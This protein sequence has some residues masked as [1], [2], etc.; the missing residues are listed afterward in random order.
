[1]SEVDQLVSKVDFGR[2][3]NDNGSLFLADESGQLL[4]RLKPF[5]KKLIDLVLA[6]K[7]L[8]QEYEIRIQT[9]EGLLNV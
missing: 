8:L 2:I 6:L 1:M 7:D 3:V 9:L 5:E 4:F